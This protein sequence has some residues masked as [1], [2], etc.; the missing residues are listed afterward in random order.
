MFTTLIRFDAVY[1]G[2]FKCNKKRILDYPVL[3]N[4]P[5]NLS[6]YPVYQHPGIAQTVDIGNIKATT[7]CH[8]KVLI[9]LA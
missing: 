9:Q 4:Y 8:T 2:H 6:Q 7:M 1:F 5:R 3:F